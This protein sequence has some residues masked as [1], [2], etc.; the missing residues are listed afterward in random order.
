MPSKDTEASSNGRTADFGSAYEGSNPSA[1]NKPVA[2]RAANQRAELKPLPMP[3]R[4]LLVALGPVPK[5]L[6]PEIGAALL[7]AFSA[8]S[9]LG[10]PQ[11]RPEH[12]F[13]KDRNQ[14]H[15]T[16]VLRRLELLRGKQ[17]QEPVLGVVDL[18]LFIP[19]QPFVFGEADREARTALLS[20]YRLKATADGRA[21]APERLLHRARLEAIHEVG[22]LLGLSHCA[23]F[24]CAM[25]L[26]HTAA[27][28]D[29]KG[30]GL[31]GQCRG[32]I[33]QP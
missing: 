20:V 21:V 24:R 12:A 32:A 2:G 30:D 28:A 27:D 22:H 17:R 25:F 9:M 1:S 19:D 33:G 5:G 6:L 11:V 29:R 7:G 14:Y 10:A 26:S 15:S 13:N 4:L 18:D 3:A 31:C 23:D 16:A 8:P